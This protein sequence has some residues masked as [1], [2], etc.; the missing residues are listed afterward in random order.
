MNLSSLE[1]TLKAIFFQQALGILMI[2]TEGFVIEANDFYASFYGKKREELIGK[3]FREY[4]TFEF[5]DP[6]LKEYESLVSGEKE[7]S[8]TERRIIH[9][10]GTIRWFKIFLSVIKHEGRPK[11]IVAT[12]VDITNDKRERGLMKLLNEID[13]SLISSKDEDDLI[14]GVLSLIVEEMGWTEAHFWKTD[15]SGKYMLSS[16]VNSLGETMIG[17]SHANSRFEELSATIKEAS[18]HRTTVWFKNT[19]IIPLTLE[20]RIFGV[21]EFTTENPAKFNLVS[22]VIFSGIA[23]R[24]SLYLQKKEMDAKLLQT[25]KMATLGELAAGIAH[26]INNPLTMVFGK[27]C[28]LESILSSEA[29]FNKS[30]LL[31]KIQLIKVFSERIV[32]IISSLRS[33]ARMGMEQA[34]ASI[35]VQKLINESLFIYQERFKARGIEL[36]INLPEKKIKVFCQS[37]LIQ[38]VIL[39]LLQN[40]KDAVLSSPRP[41]KVVE[42]GAVVED[43]KV[44]IYVKD[45]GTGVSQEV[46]DSLFLPFVTTKSVESGTGLGLS[47]SKGIVE[48]HKGK[49]WFD[50]SEEGSTF[51]FDLPLN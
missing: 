50:S 14:S 16:S 17:V 22:P 6:S 25:A 45:N 33:F 15:L 36:K 26:E 39:N 29:D 27:A 34:F 10:D 11:N 37:I 18:E 28:Q 35:T 32:N 42:V 7:S 20:A 19:L 31:E 1:E 13:Q 23:Q 8:S 49:I 2:D 41:S 5:E 30:Q 4:V 21:L 46:W 12:F 47:I 9:P 44:R 40:A 38:S 43:N 48:A 51:Q 24:V 3:N